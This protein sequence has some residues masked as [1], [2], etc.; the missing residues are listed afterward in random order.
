MSL[1]S[2]VAVFF[3]ALSTCM[4][5]D[6]VVAFSR[7][8]QKSSH[9]RR[10]YEPNSLVLMFESDTADR[11]AAVQRMPIHGERDAPVGV[12]IDAQLTLGELTHVWILGD[13]SGTSMG[14]PKEWNGESSGYRQL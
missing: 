11:T 1:P 9:F 12:A 6:L 4:H 8:I 7:I 14:R 13:G 3:V 2:P 5:R 10:V